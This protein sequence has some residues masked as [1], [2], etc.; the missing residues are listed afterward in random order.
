VKSR[1]LNR[2]IDTQEEHHRTRNFQQEYRILLKRHG[3][4][5]DERYVWGSR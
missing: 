1:G 5:C 2:Y 3:V 4:E